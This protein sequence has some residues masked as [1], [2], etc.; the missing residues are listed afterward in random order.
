MNT[1][2]LWNGRRLLALALASGS[3]LSACTEGS[4]EDPA[5]DQAEDQ[6]DLG[7]PAFA[8]VLKDEAQ[9]YADDMAFFAVRRTAYQRTGSIPSVPPSLS[10]NPSDPEY[11]FLRYVKVA[12]AAETASY[13]A[14]L[15][16]L[17]IT[18]PSTAELADFETTFEQDAASGIHGVY[19]TWPG[20]AAFT[21]RD[22]SLSPAGRYRLNMDLPGR[23]WLSVGPRGSAVAIASGLAR[24]AVNAAMRR[25]VRGAGGTTAAAAAAATA[26][27]TAPAVPTPPARTSASTVDR[28]RD[29]G[30]QFGIPSVEF[31]LDVP[32]YTAVSARPAVAAIAAGGT[33]TAVGAVATVAAK[34]PIHSS[35]A[36]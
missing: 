1:K 19:F 11:V 6:A 5:E 22:S 34:H 27:S 23:A 36:A 32:S 14:R 29:G 31:D 25:L 10:T 20:S 8:A 17:A 3:A 18:P 16:N 13:Q 26:L 12:T 33:I 2:S 28:Y 9:R 7:G 35:D 30:R 4:P 24:L 21:G 15:E